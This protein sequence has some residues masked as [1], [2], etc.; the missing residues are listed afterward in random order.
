VSHLQE[1]SGRP[2]ARKERGAAAGQPEFHDLVADIE[3]LNTWEPFGD[4]W[5]DHLELMADVDVEQDW[6]AD[7]CPF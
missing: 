7:D 3:L 4:G 5:D 2:A 6:G 1:A